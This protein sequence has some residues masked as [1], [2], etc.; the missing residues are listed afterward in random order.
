M[1]EP[2]IA[3]VGMAC[4]FPGAGNL[5]TF[6]SNICNGVDAIT[7]MPASGWDRVFYDPSSRAVDRIPCRRGGFIDAHARFDPLRHGVMPVAAN[8]AEP[9]QLLALEVAARALEDAGYGA[10]PLQ[11]TGVILGRAAI[12]GPRHARMS[13]HIRSA[14]QL[15][16]ALR[17]LVPDI[18]EEDLSGIKAEFQRK[19]NAGTL[20]EGVIGL[21]PNL[22]AS[23]IAGRFDFSGAAYTID[24][25][26]ASSLIAVDHACL[27]LRCGRADMMLCG[28]VQL[29]RDE[30]FWSVFG[31]LGA[32]SPSECIRPF[33]AGADGLL[34]GEGVGV[35]ALRREAD[36]QR[37]GNRIY[38]VIRGTGTSSDG[39][40]ASLVSPR[41]EGQL[42]ALEAAWHASSVQP[43]AVGLIEAHGTGTPTGDAAEV[44]TLRRFF[45][46]GGA[47]RVGL[48]SVKSMIG[49]TMPAAGAAGLIKAALGVY[50]SLKPGTLHCAQPREDL[51]GTVFSV[52][53]R[54][55]RWD[56]PR[57]V[58][59]VNAFG[60]GGVNAH[61]IIESV[62]PPS[63]S[64]ERRRGARAA[65]RLPEIEPPALYAAHSTEALRDAL[66]RDERDGQGSVRLCVLGVTPERRELAQR[67]VARNRPLHGHLGISFDTRAL[68]ARGGS[69]A[70]LFPGFDA[71]FEP[72]A[73]D[74]VDFLGEEPIEP[75]QDGIIGQA[76]AIL[77][78]NALLYRALGVL[79]VEPN[80]VAGHSLGDMNA[81]V[82]GGMLDQPAID[83]LI[84]ALDPGNL[85]IAD[86]LYVA[87]GCDLQAARRVIDGVEGAVISHDNC[88]HQVIACTAAPRLDELQRAA[89]RAG[90]LAHVLPFRVGLHTP[91]VEPMLADFGA[92]ARAASF[93]QP[94]CTVYSATTA[95]PYPANDERMRA[96]VVDHMV[97]PLRFR[98]LI[99]RMHE[100][101]IRAF[102]Q[103]GNGSLVQFVEDTL[104]GRPHVAV[105]AGSA[106]CSAREQL[107]RVLCS[108]WV[109]GADVRWD[110]LTSHAGSTAVEPAEQREQQ[111]HT[112][113]DR[114][115]LLDLSV[116]FVHFDRA[117]AARPDSLARAAVDPQRAGTPLQAAL[118]RN[119]QLL[120]HAQRDVAVAASSASARDR[121]VAPE[122]AQ[123]GGAMTRVVR[124]RVDLT[125]WPELVDHSFQRQP[126]R[127]QQSGEGQSVVPLTGI[128]WLMVDAV[129]ELLPGKHA[130]ELHDVT[131][132][133]LFGVGE[134]VDL[135]ITC[136]YDGH[137]RVDFELGPYAKGFA[138]VSD[139]YPPRPTPSRAP[140]ARERPAPNVARE[141]Y[142]DRWMFH[143]PAYQGVISLDAIGDDGA[144][145]RVRCLP[146]RGALLDCAAQVL[147]YWVMASVEQDRLTIPMHVEHVFLY[148]PHPAPGVE[149]VCE[150]EVRSID[151]RTVTG[152][153]TLSSD[154]GVWAHVEG[155]I[156]RRVRADERMWELI[157]WP[158]RSVLCITPEPGLAVLHDGYRDILTREFL[159]YCYLGKEERGSLVTVHPRERRSW[160]A[161]RIAAKDA[162][163]HLAWARGASPTFPIEV[164]IESMGA[165]VFRT[166][167]PDGTS[168]WVATDNEGD[169][170]VA[171]ASD[172]PG[173]FVSLKPAPD[174]SPALVHTRLSDDCR[175]S[176]AR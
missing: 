115:V 60:F 146:A 9:D 41:V 38:A 138:R 18:R 53:S 134:G 71:A 82:A 91:Y 30:A 43:D 74:L 31:Q 108:L 145:G 14:E 167:L 113:V 142:E 175:V 106:K 51:A 58:A 120:S 170:T 125:T 104:R 137:D 94:R 157:R 27:E 110:R 85:P 176:W 25:A 117:L 111:T 26:C 55:E 165:D 116:P 4:I 141:L 152:N 136:R 52:Q 158:E 168:F 11:R 123:R 133:R 59:G 32:L 68:L 171:L 99:E 105:S 140:L 119:L 135:E 127:W 65:T 161:R 75:S 156:D 122:S 121:V 163:R 100:D 77:R 153:L 84:A 62:A 34:I 69:V 143:G 1:A 90:V 114:G 78:T 44:E 3:I 17:E 48:G 150:A 61:V 79:G 162:I 81:L 73:R 112:V 10:R 35:L 103:V 5:A 72:P 173:P 33:D 22:L 148:G 154:A 172:R 128:L 87:L 88:P 15:V 102:V 54:T 67:I 37:D 42:R 149:L 93:H 147:G 101:G 83:R 169:T 131:A 64:P 8:A 124:R 50:H 46:D 107:S 109:Q 63:S 80:A 45:G 126:E 89:D 96:I 155:W 24:A 29:S 13:Q 174:R 56:Q 144:R 21:V 151:E 70:F 57:R 47:R 98:E 49:H 7:D 36:A 164:S 139:Q 2:G 12:I 28:G 16:V 130:I 159:E 6:W 86:V 23:R 76:K 95:A 39:K 160:L 166:Q 129:A 19:N 132:M 66:A 20:A 118:Q 97:K 92:I 40:G